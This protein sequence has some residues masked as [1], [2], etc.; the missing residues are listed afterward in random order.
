MGWRV[1]LDVTGAGYEAQNGASRKKMLRRVVEK[2]VLGRIW[3][4]QPHH[5]CPQAIGRNK[6]CSQLQGRVYSTE[7]MKGSSGGNHVESKMK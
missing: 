3:N 4:H 7:Y 5:M 2:G 1:R 6:S